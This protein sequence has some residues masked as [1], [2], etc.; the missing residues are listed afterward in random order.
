ML[1]LDFYTGLPSSTHM[2]DIVNNDPPGFVVHKIHGLGLSFFFCVESICPS[3]CAVLCVLHVLCCACC[4]FSLVRVVFAVVS[5][6]F[7]VF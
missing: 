5:V 3:V 6:V 4:I 7:A 2:A 1:V